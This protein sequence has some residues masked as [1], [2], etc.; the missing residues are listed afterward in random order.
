MTKAP[1]VN[2]GSNQ[3]GNEAAAITIDAALSGIALV[4][5]ARFQGLLLPLQLQQTQLTSCAALNHATGTPPGMKRCVAL[6]TSA[7]HRK[8]SR[9]TACTIAGTH[10]LSALRP[11]LA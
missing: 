10:L 5:G 3:A 8:M 11:A 7:F 9:A 2:R 4:K 6:I 1:G